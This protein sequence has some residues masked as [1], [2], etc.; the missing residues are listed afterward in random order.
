MIAAWAMDQTTPSHKRLKAAVRYTVAGHHVADFRARLGLVK[1]L[2]PSIALRPRFAGLTALT[3]SSAEPQL[4]SYVMA[5]V[6]GTA[7]W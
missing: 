7:L 2:R 1:A 3:G 5:G 6:N 4:G